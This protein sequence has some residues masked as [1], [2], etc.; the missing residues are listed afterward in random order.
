MQ[1]CESVEMVLTPFLDSL[2]LI[3]VLPTYLGY[4]DRQH[5]DSEELQK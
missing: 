1:K 4:A 3:F 5:T 2:K